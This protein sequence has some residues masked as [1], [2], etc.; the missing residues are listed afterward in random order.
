MIMSRGLRLF[1]IGIVVGVVA[2]LGATRF[3]SSLLF[4]VLPTDGLT[5][6]TVIMALGTVSLFAVFVPALRATRV[7]P[8]MAIRQE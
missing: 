5:F 7:D 6:A 3:I 4:G 2:A 8:I 1:G